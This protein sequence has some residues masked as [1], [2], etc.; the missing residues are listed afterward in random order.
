MLELGRIM[1][2]Q[3]QMAYELLWQGS[4][5]PLGCEAARCS[6][7]DIELAEVTTAAQ[8]S[9]SKLPRHR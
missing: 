2:E 8:S 6:F 5:L 7:N 1:P 4:L 9:G 3:K